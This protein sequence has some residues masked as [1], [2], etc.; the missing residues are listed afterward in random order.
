M[1]PVGC[2]A[3]R[4]R[5]RDGGDGDDVDDDDDDDDDDY[6]GQTVTRPSVHKT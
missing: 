6:Y 3:L 1:Q 4:E 5:E 2:G